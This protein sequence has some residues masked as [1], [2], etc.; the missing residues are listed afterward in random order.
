M[1]VPLTEALVTFDVLTGLV[2]DVIASPAPRCL[3]SWFWW[4]AMNCR[5]RSRSRCR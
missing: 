3:W 4:L 1:P 2:T 5:R